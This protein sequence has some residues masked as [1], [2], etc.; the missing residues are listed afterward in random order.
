MRRV[1][2]K[3]NTGSWKQTAAQ[4]D[5][6]LWPGELWLTR[7]ARVHPGSPDRQ[8]AV[9]LPVAPS[10]RGVRPGNQPTLPEPSRDCRLPIDRQNSRTMARR[11]P[12]A[13]LGVAEASGG[14]GERPPASASCTEP[15]NRR[16]RPLRSHPLPGRE[17]GGL[18]VASASLL[19]DR[20]QRINCSALLF[21]R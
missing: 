4:A 8:A 6:S 19:T 14:T 13:S 10:G 12:L 15:G 16:P 5:R 1:P 3:P 17:G 11:Q 21:S 18:L 9:T 7:P 2:P 20:I